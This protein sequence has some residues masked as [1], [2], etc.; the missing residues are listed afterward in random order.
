[1]ART[2]LCAVYRR[3]CTVS[4]CLVIEAL[5]N[6]FQ[7]LA[8]NFLIFLEKGACCIIATTKFLL[9]KAI[10]SSGFAYNSLLLAE[11]K[12]FASSVDHVKELAC[13]ADGFLNN[14]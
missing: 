11:R 8:C 9:T 5:A 13:I 3:S 4:P 2:G 1:M 12:Q 10:R 6:L 7:E 14:G